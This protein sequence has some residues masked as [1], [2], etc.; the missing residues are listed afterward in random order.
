MRS[1]M[2]VRSSS[3]CSRGS[4]KPLLM[5]AELPG[6]LSTGLTSFLLAQRFLVWLVGLEILKL[7]L[8]LAILY[9]SLQR[10]HA[11]WWW[12][13]DVP[14]VWL[15][16]TSMARANEL[17]LTCLPSDRTPQMRTDCREY[18]ELAISC[19]AYVNRLCR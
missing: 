11:A 15:E 3:Q 13:G 4:A 19:A 9:L 16:L 7:N 8:Q 17:A 1:L 5:G 12:T 2:P 18:L 6:S 14:S 10:V